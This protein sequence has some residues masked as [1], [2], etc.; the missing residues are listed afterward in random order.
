MPEIGT[1]DI[2]LG[3]LHKAIAK[4]LKLHVA[5]VGCAPGGDQGVTLTYIGFPTL[6]IRSII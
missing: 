4:R 2:E 6:F 1:K 3:E 5:E